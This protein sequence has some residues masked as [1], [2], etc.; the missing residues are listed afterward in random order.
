VRIL[1]LSVFALL[2]VSCLP[3]TIPIPQPTEI[4]LTPLPEGSRQGSVDAIFISRA[5]AAGQGKERCHALIRLYPD[6]RA[7]RADNSCFKSPAEQDLSAV[8]GWFEIQNSPFQQGDYFVRDSR[9]WIRIVE[10]NSILETM[11]LRSFQGELCGNRLVLQ[12]PELAWYAGVPSPIT[13]PVLEYD[14]LAGEQMSEP[15][16]ADCHAAGFN[17]LFRPAASLAGGKAQ[18]D[19]ATDPHQPCTL[20]YI[21]PPGAAAGSEEVYR[22]TADSQGLCRWLVDLGDTTGVARFI[23]SIDEITQQFSLDVR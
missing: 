13:Q 9:I 1:I 4:A 6:G 18:V 22:I 21:P 2:M 3:P 23:I 14:R 16:P 17:I 12:E 20:Q 7:L 11:S 5:S 15:P 8:Q 10:Y 19:I